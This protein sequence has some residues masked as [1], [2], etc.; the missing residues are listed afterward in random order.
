MHALNPSFTR[1]EVDGEVLGAGGLPGFYGACGGGE[2]TGEGVDRAYL[3]G[4]DG[5][6]G[7]G[8]GFGSDLGDGGGEGFGGER[9]GLPDIGLA[10]G[11]AQGGVR[12]AT[13]QQGERGALN[14]ERLEDA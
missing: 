4:R 11:S 7:G 14:G 2:V 5:G 6:G 12:P 1:A 9:G 3:D 13:D 8:A 10:T